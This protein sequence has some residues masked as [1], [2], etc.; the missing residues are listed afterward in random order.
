MQRKVSYV[1]LPSFFSFIFFLLFLLG[2]ITFGRNRPSRLRVG[3]PP[4]PH[5]FLAQDRAGGSWD[6]GAACVRSP[7]HT[8]GHFSPSRF[9][10][11]PN[12][13]KKEPPPK[14]W[15]KNRGGRYTRVVY[16]ARVSG[17]LGPQ[18]GSS[19]RLSAICRSGLQPYTPPVLLLLSSLACHFGRT[20][21]WE[22]TFYLS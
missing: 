9:A 10:P 6:R 8:S 20:C 22:M 13:K 15:F 18:S 4:P 2:D 5:H 12:N 1:I 16:A 17:H 3:G 7:P 14:P 19:N 21:T 11:S